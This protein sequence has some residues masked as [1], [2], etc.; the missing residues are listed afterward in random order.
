MKR[1]FLAIS[2]AAVTALTSTSICAFADGQNSEAL[3]SAIKIAK[4][5]LDI[6]EELTE[7]SYDTSDRYNTTV[8]CLTWTTPSDAAEY[9]YVSVTVSGSLVLGYFNSDSY[10]YDEKCE[11]FAKLS[12]DELYKKAQA[13]VKKLD[14]TVADVILIDRDSLNINVYGKRAYFSLVRTKNG[15]PVSN[16]RGSVSLDKDT[17]ELIGFNLGWH[18]NAS[19]RDSK[20]AI[21]LDKAKQK[22]A[23]MI[24]LTPQYEFDYDWETKKLT[25]QL[26]YRQNDFGEINAFTGKKSNFSAD[27]YY[28]DSSNETME[29]DTADEMDT[30]K[31]D[32]GYQF[33]EQEQAELDKKLPYADSAAVI[34]LIQADKWMTYSTDMELVYSDLYKV[35]FTGKDKYYY[36]ANFSS[37]VP[38]ENDDVYEEIVEDDGSVSVPA[39]EPTQNWQEVNITVDAE[40]G[41]VMSYYFWDSRDN[42]SNS[43]DLDKA[44]KLA[45]EIAK[46]YAG[47]RFAEYKGNPSSDYS[48]TD[49]NDKTTYSG[50][51][52]TW[53]RYSNDILV[54]GDSIC[55][56]F[57]AD[58]KLTRYDYSYTDVKLPDPSRMLSTDMVMQK[59]WEN[60]D[61]NLYYL[62]KFVDKK[63]KTV[64]VYGTDSYV[65]VDATTGEPVYSWAYEREKNDLSGIKN[66]KIL[67][68]A[69]ALDDHGYI[70]SAQKFSEN[71]IA[72]SETFEQLMGISTGENSKKLTLGDA[73]VIFTKSV[74]GDKIPELKG[75]YKSPFSDVK[76][77]DK[78]VGYYAIA[79]AMGVVSGDKLN[80]KSDFTYGDMIKMVYTLYTAE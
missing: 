42:S 73:L 27:G 16:D 19:F 76:D 11:H 80:A 31:G 18:A 22:Y 48:W 56:N 36:T 2:M 21:S 63:T 13:A 10:K 78:N 20:S 8:Y 69:K 14:P 39:A 1:R 28:D 40:S 71:D 74:A 43:Y 46:T 30:G 25:A 24:Q 6:P 17:G 23:E 75:I 52:H 45:E 64:L 54:S 4:T 79:Y 60:N 57:N 3:A 7:F 65:Y 72:D 58:T 29:E 66:K 68:M 61:L 44:D 12:G 34:K 15:V 26:V 33:T 47:D 5:R 41:Q 55:I 35:S 77:T 67:K 32:G 70:I 37:Y 62:A 53:D 49:K 51:S 50:S 38:D 59:F 9:K